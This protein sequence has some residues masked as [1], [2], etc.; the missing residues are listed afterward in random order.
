LSPTL[1][2]TQ[3][4][5]RDAAALLTA[6]FIAGLILR[7]LAGWS[8]PSAL[9]QLSA[10]G[11][12]WISPLRG[13]IRWRLLLAWSVPFFAWAAWRDIAGGDK[14]SSVEGAFKGLVYALALIGAAS[15]LDRRQWLMAIS[16]GVLA[17]LLGVLAYI[18]TAELQVALAAAA[19]QGDPSE[20][21]R[22]NRG[23]DTRMN[24]NKLAVFLGMMATWSALLLCLRPRRWQWLLALLV[25]ATWFLLLSNFGVG[26]IVGSCAAV[27]VMIL[28][29]RP[30]WVLPLASLV[31][32]VIAG[33]HLQYPEHVNVKSLMNMRDVIYA[34][35]WPHVVRF[36]WEGAGSAYFKDVVSPTLSTGPKPFI[37]NIYLEFWL[38]YG[39][40]GA[41]LLG[42]MV[43]QLARQTAPLLTSVEA[44]L[45]IGS[46]SAFFLVYGL[47]DMKPMNPYFFIGIACMGLLIGTIA[48]ALP[49]TLPGRNGHPRHED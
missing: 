40:I 30:R 5:R 43:I 17:G 28:L 26:S 31:L 33:M 10:F 25:P 13:Q 8:Y 35:T 19:G 39:L 14:L 16:T 12:I 29:V 41:A 24:R 47:V 4:L 6:L 37:H 21:M 44:R 9:L 2:L 45:V 48:K 46:T 34:E 42:L 15:M 23:F 27:A 38:A 18:G 22:M 7:G 32:L 1:P 11:L 20:P 3:L 49:G 36:A